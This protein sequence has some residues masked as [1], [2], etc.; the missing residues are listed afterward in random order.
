MDD[1]CLELQRS[2]MK[3]LA[4]VYTLDSSDVFTYSTNTSGIISGSINVEVDANVC[5]QLIEAS[6]TGDVNWQHVE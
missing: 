5:Q 3:A 4:A 2:E 1:E 6:D